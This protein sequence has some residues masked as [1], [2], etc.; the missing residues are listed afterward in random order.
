MKFLKITILHVFCFLNRFHYCSQL[1]AQSLAY[2][3]LAKLS[4]MSMF[5][6]MCCITSYASYVYASLVVLVRW[7]VHGVFPVVN[8]C[9]YGH[10]QVFLM[11]RRIFPACFLYSSRIRVFQT[12]VTWPRG[13][14]CHFVW[15]VA[16]FND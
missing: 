5:T 13:Y 4:P 7:S 11:K 8:L 9:D 15:S 10:I 1:L 16:V 12:S 3:S 6:I 14:Y 2:A